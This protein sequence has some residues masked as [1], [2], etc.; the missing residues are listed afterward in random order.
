MPTFTF[1]SPDG[2]NY[3]VQGPEGA[4]KEQAFAILQQRLGPPSGAS[5]PASGGAAAPA[6]KPAPAQPPQSVAGFVGGNLAKGVAD[7]VGP[8]AEKAQSLVD[9]PAKAFN[10][11]LDIVTGGKKTAP[12]LPTTSKSLPVGD[13]AL[14]A[15]MKKVGVIGP[16]AEPRSTAQR[17][18]AAALR[19]LP[20]AALPGAGETVLGRVLPQVGGAIGGEAGQD[21][22]GTPGRIAGT[23]L[24]GAG[25]GLATTR[26][27]Q[28]ARPPQS[29]AARAAESSGIPLTL[30]QETGSSSL[31]FLENR[32]R[33]LFPSKGTANADEARQ[34]AA[35]AR[36]VNELADQLSAGGTADAES[37]GNR[38][39]GA[40]TETVGK[41]AAARDKQ[42]SADYGK[43][44]ALAGDKPVIK[45][46]NTVDELK[47][48]ISEN[49]NVPAG[50]A[51]KIAKQARSLL[52]QLT[53]TPTV[54]KASPILL[55]TG[56]PASVPP[57]PVA[58][59][60]ST[61]VSDAMKTR[62]AWG[63]AARR[64]G[65]IFT[66]IDPNANQ[67]LARRLFGA[68]NKDFDAASTADTPIAKALKDANQNYAKASKSIEFID[69]SALGKLLGKD[70]TDA[71]FTGETFSTKAPEAIAKR[72]LSMEPSQAA[73]VTAILREHAPQVL[74]DAKSFVLRN[75]LE[76]ARNTAPGASGI[77]FS[78]FRREIDRVEPKLADMGFTA[79]E[80]K[81]IKDVTDTMSRAGDRTGA[82]P[83]GTSAAAHMIG[84]GGLL[85]THP[86]AGVAA[87]V[88]PYIASKALLTEGGRELLRKAYSGGTPAVRNAAMGSLRAAYGQ[89]AEQLPSTPGG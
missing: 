61:T 8:I 58:G 79:K 40:Y 29:E 73:Q 2:K 37:I 49:E 36:R 43:V 32:L 12:Q 77:S 46:Q 16:S 51:V 47:K 19:A 33:E 31:Q 34:V 23:L 24:G 30:G 74:Q 20:A 5:S 25:G 78:K 50:D 10:K 64:T 3:D 62:S 11:A 81:D 60:K 88:T 42:A 75:G 57:P 22:F 21:M 54:Q 71:A 41:I 48:I 68:V 27:S 38:L 53:E 1:T 65:N 63:K 4:T 44:R 83:S 26:P 55:P 52:D 59:A 28:I 15:A 87:V 14:Q 76:Q 45:Y 56:K 86:V 17:Y 69:Q 9:L 66:D 85:F 84:T 80:I 13:E 35:G 89:G 18:G 67:V 6:A 39:R 70:V 82:N 72:Y 7:T